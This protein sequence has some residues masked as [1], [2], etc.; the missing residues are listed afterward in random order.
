MLIKKIIFLII[1]LSALFC[2]F[3]NSFAQQNRPHLYF[4]EQYIDGG[5]MNV[6]N[7]FTFGWLTVMLDLRPA[8]ETINTSVVYVRIDKIADNNGFY[9]PEIFIDTIKFNVEPDWDYTYF[10]D[11]SNLVFRESGVYRVSVDTDYG[12][13]IASSFLKIIEETDNYFQE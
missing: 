1:I 10:T 12:G 13:R 7:T 9:S 8:N 2:R 11:E 4:C 5:E 6:A 3:N